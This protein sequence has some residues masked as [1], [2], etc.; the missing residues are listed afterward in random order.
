MYANF[1]NDI[2]SFIPY[3]ESHIVFLPL[4]PMREAH[5]VD[6]SLLFSQT[7]IVVSG[8]VCASEPYKVFMLFEIVF[9]IW[10]KLKCENYR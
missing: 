7:E 9:L 5:T 2:F 6:F 10:K 1:E 3:N 4:A 8:I